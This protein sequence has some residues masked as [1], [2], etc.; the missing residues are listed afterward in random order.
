MM[1]QNKQPKEGFSLFSLFDFTLTTKGRSYLKQLFSTPLLSIPKIMSRQN[2]VLV[3]AVLDK[4]SSHSS[5]S[6]GSSSLYL[7]L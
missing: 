7:D 1:I 4:V 6:D 2:S 5:A 3:L